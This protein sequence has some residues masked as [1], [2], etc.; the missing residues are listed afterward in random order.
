[1]FIGRVQLQFYALKILENCLF[2]LKWQH[3]RHKKIIAGDQIFLK[4][5]LYH[6]SW[7][8]FLSLSCH[9]VKWLTFISDEE[10]GFDA[11]LCSVFTFIYLSITCIGLGDGLLAVPE[12]E[13]K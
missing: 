10:N 4:A 6:I 1:M 13:E 8:A 11:R 5:L 7:Q 9:E 12:L 3:Q 2:Q